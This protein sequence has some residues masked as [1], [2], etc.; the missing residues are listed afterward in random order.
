MFLR[1]CHSEPYLPADDL[2]HSPP[3]Q[4]PSYRGLCVLVCPPHPA[5][6][7]PE[8]TATS[9]AGVEQASP[10]RTTPLAKFP[11]ER[12]ETMSTSSASE[13]HSSATTE[14]TSPSIADFC[15]R[16]SITKSP[17]LPQ[18]DGEESETTPAEADVQMHP[19]EPMRVSS[20][21]KTQEPDEDSHALPSTGSD[22][23]SDSSSS[24]DDSEE[25]RPSCILLNALHVSDIFELPSFTRPPPSTEEV[26]VGSARF[27]PAKLP[28]QINLRNLNIQQIKY[29]SISDI[30]IYAKYG[31]GQGVLEV[32]ESIAHAQEEMWQRRM[33]E[34]YSHVVNGEGEGINR[35]VRYG[36]WVVV[37]EW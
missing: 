28:Q 27:R 11:R 37:G 13:S 14:G 5:D 33:Q 8:R 36:V 29:A 4:P 21:A 23:Q 12:S 32:A 6:A 15:P 7:A 18:I 34:F 26:E 1:V 31:V 10:D 19:C 22:V 25:P 30:V 9:T 35:P 17:N 16:S 3:F 2:R 20:Q 24:S